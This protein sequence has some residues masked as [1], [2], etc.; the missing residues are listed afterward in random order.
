MWR[1]ISPAK[2][3]GESDDEANRNRL[4][5]LDCGML[6][7]VAAQECA[8]DEG[9]MKRGSGLRFVLLVALAAS[10]FMR[11]AII[12]RMHSRDYPY[13]RYEDSAEQIKLSEDGFV[14][15]LYGTDNRIV[16]AHRPRV[17]Y[18]ITHCPEADYPDVSGTHGQLESADNQRTD[19]PIP[20][21]E[22]YRKSQ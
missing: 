10:S 9:K 20:P 16:E 14:C 4:R 6:R 12:Q 11:I 8:G 22:A 19:L 3:A 13:R 17:D 2:N 15:I 7:A 18:G 1:L 21:A 5:V